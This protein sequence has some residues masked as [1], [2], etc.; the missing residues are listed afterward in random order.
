M[1]FRPFDPKPETS[2]FRR[3]LPH[4]RQEGSTYF[5]T[6]RLADSLP[7]EKLAAWSAER[8]TWLRARGLDSPTEISK[9]RPVERAEYFNHFGEKLEAWLDE[10]F[11][12]CALARP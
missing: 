10:G 12:E 1:K 5:V 7:A 4:W 2:T 3:N 11:G 8:D 9:I 6:W